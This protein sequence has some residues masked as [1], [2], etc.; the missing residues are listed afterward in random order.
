MT[1]TD[2]RAQQSEV[3]LET[4]IRSATLGS[5]PE[6]DEAWAEI[7]RRHDP[8][9]YRVIR[10]T[11]QRWYPCFTGADVIDDVKQATWCRAAARNGAALRECA[12]NGGKPAALLVRL[13][14]WETMKW[15]RWSVTRREIPID[16]G[17]FREVL[18][19]QNRQLS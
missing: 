7:K 10:K 11:L 2:K 1:S 19:R 13:A 3:R 14:I 9:L 18:N 5:T 16:M 4:L 8:L 6:C 15:H 12:S 17:H